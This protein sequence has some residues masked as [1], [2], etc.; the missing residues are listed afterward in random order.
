MPIRRTFTKLA[1]R[2][3]QCEIAFG[4]KFDNKLSN[5]PLRLNAAKRWPNFDMLIFNS[6]SSF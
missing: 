2:R 1:K 5:E 4:N 6:D 3:L